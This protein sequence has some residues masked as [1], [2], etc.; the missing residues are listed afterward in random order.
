MITGK[1]VTKVDALTLDINTKTVSC[2][3]LI[4]YI[5]IAHIFHFKQ[6]KIDLQATILVIILILKQVASFDAVN[7]GVL[8]SLENLVHDFSINYYIVLELCYDENTLR[9]NTRLESKGV[10]NFFQFLKKHYE[11]KVSLDRRTI[12]CLYVPG[13]RRQVFIHVNFLYEQ[14]KEM[15]EQKKNKMSVLVAE[16]AYISQNAQFDLVMK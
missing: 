8:Y 7:F 2:S 1:Q 5:I 12:L 6:R 4:M 3:T 16:S 9:F 13:F 10:T 15:K 11:A 14:S